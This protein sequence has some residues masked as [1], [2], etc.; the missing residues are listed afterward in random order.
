MKYVVFLIINYL[1][2]AL[3][4]NQAQLA[5]GAVEA[6]QHRKDVHSPGVDETAADLALYDHRVAYVPL[7]VVVGGR[8]AGIS[9]ERKQVGRR[10]LQGGGELVVPVR[11]DDVSHALFE[12]CACGV[13]G[14]AAVLRF[15]RHMFG[16]AKYLEQLEV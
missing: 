14:S 11:R 7:G 5:A 16:V 6:L 1:L 10:T 4:R 2:H 15:G 13:T 3:P 9:E 12:L 8:H